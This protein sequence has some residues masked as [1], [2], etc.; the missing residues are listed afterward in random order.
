MCWKQ[1]PHMLL[2]WHP[3]VIFCHPP[4]LS[5]ILLH[6]LLY[7]V[8]REDQWSHTVSFYLTVCYICRLKL[9]PCS[10][11]LTSTGVWTHT[12][13]RAQAACLEAQADV[14]VGFVL[15]HQQEICYCTSKASNTTVW[16]ISSRHGGEGD[17]L[18]MKKSEYIVGNAVPD[19]HKKVWK[20]VKEWGEA[21]M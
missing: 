15:A 11:P 3:S 19:R 6:Q 18:F 8:P 1:W 7:K 9:Q 20:R 14:L 16:C 10:T 2:C 13:W 21:K 5:T 4:C 12:R 17:L